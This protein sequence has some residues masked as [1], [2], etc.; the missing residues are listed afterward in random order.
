MKKYLFLLI[1]ALVSISAL[2][3]PA[4]RTLTHLTQPDGTRIAAL[5][6]GDEYY[7]YYTDALTGHRLTCD[8]QTGF[9]RAM[10]AEEKMTSDLQWQ[11]RRAAMTA[12]KPA[13]RP[14]M[15]KTGSDAPSPTLGH[16]RLPC[17]LVNWSDHSFSDIWKQDSVKYHSTNDLFEDMMNGGTGYTFGSA[18]GAANQYFLDQSY[19]K[20][21]AEFDIIGPIT[22]SKRHDC[23]KNRNFSSAREAWKEALDSAW[24]QGIMTAEMIDQW[25]ND[26][27]GLVDLIYVFYAGYNSSEGNANKDWVWPH[28][29]AFSGG[30]NYPGSNSWFYNYSCSG[31]FAG[32]I[33]DATHPLDGIG[34]VVH[35]FGHALGLPDFYQTGNGADVYGM[36][37][38]SVMD[39]GCYNGN[40]HVPPSYNTFERMSFDWVTPIEL[41]D[42]GTIILPPFDCDST[43]YILYNP[44][45]EDEFLTF[46][47]HKQ[48]GWDY[49]YGSGYF[50]TTGRYTDARG[51]LITHVDYD[52]NLWFQNKVNADP[53]HQHCT[54]LPADGVLTPYVDVVTYSQFKDFQD[55]FLADVFPG[56]D[57]VTSLNPET[58][59]TMT[60]WTGDTIDLVLSNI[61]ILANG[62]VQMDVL[63]PKLHSINAIEQISADPARSAQ[64][65]LICRDGQL[66]LRRGEELFDLRGARLF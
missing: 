51:L 49:Y 1:V 64:A 14:K 56:H 28:N 35:E 20:Y 37:S 44:D 39:V 22:I 45:N 40:G 55:K 17:L 60:W 65:R 13:R 54:L 23:A 33:T 19:G 50:T 4:R 8:T 53:N 3:K 30:I 38:W 16:H 42:S 57:Q 24:S 63:Q 31:E 2:A 41:P 10:T 15:L 27:D 32:L 48:Q 26:G 12:D 52:P 43:C 25:D 34:T 21:E 9:W 66:L 11:Q 47:C 18:V 61:E 58:N 29:W 46:E 59:P 7:Q 5:W 6:N 62:S 36:L